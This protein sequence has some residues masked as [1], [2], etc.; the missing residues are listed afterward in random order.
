MFVR[1]NN[2]HVRVNNGSTAMG[3]GFKIPRNER[4][5]EQSVHFNVPSGQSVSKK[6]NNNV[7]KITKELKSL[8]MPSNPKAIKKYIKF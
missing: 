6:L 5:K 4:F 3:C 1:V 8:A 2:G 7:E